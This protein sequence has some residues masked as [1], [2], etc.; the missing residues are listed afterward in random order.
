MN[1][2]FSIIGCQHAHIAIFLKEMLEQ[3]HTCA[4]IYEPENRMLATKMS[5]KFQVPI[6]EDIDELLADSIALVGCAAKNNEKIDI[7][8]RCER[9]GKSIM[10]DKPAVTCREDLERLESILQR[11]KIQVGMLLTERFRPAVYTLKRLIEEH[12]LGDIISIMTRKPHRLMPENRPEWH[13][14]KKQSGGIVIDL[15][16]HDIDLLRWLTGEEITEIAGVM[17]KRILPEYPD[18]Y[19]TAALQVLIG[20]HILGQL[21]ADWHT[22]EKSWTWGDGR[23]FVNGTKG[24]VE[25]RLEGDPLISHDELLM[26]VTSEQ[27]WQVVDL[28]IPSLTIT[29]DFLNR[30]EGHKGWITHQDIWMATKAA[31]EADEKMRL[32]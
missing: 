24:F 10:I 4:G 27:E 14:S 1:Y 6:V 23:I 15:L 17:G 21:Y 5:Q 22:P 28:E 30:M 11:G 9:H 32:Y 8:E 18:F 31:V 25:L 12:A 19:D 13:F 16:I 7:I 26:Q 20:D 3:G 29:Q 2:T